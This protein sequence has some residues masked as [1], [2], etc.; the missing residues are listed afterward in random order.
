MSELYYEFLDDG[1]VRVRYFDQVGYVSSAHLVIP[2]LHQLEAAH[3][4][5]EVRGPRKRVR[6]TSA[7]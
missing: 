4:K 7:S 3:D 5:E 1:S 2:K 6:R